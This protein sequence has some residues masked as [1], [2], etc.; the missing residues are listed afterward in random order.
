MTQRP[1]RSSKPS[2]IICENLKN[3]T[4]DDT[5]DEL[6]SSEVT[7]QSPLPS[8]TPLGD[9]PALQSP[10]SIIAPLSAA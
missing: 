3:L 1:I 6:N 8:P 9:T 10:S 7:Y 5:L 2:R 4:N